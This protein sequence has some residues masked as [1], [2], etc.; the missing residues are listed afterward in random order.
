MNEWK[1][2]LVHCDDSGEVLDLIANKEKEWTCDCKKERAMQTL[3]LKYVWY[4]VRTQILVGQKE[5]CW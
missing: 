3:S 4:G 2:G 1:D 5:L